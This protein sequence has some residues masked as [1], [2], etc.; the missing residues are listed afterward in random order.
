MFCPVAMNCPLQKETFSNQGELPPDG[1]CGVQILPSDEVKIELG[2]SA[3][4]VL[5]PNVRPE[6]PKPLSSALVIRPNQFVPSCDV[7]M[8]P[9]EPTV[10]NWKSPYETPS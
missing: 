4:K 9:C 3:T 5:L 10:T 2:P 8:V 1:V 6:K 7:N